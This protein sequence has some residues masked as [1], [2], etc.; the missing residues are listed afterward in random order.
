MIADLGGITA[1]IAAAIEQQGVA[2]T[3]IA[4]SAHQAALGTETISSNLAALTHASGQS[5]DAAEAGRV[6]SRQLSAQWDKMTG[7]VRTFV[8]TLQAA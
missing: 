4:R 3:E 1:S 6:A 2:T 8:G 7:S 5:G